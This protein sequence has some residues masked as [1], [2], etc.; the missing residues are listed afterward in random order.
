MQCESF[1]VA[2]PS[3]GDTKYPTNR[4]TN[5]TTDLKHDKVLTDWEVGL[6]QIQF[7]NNWNYSTPEFKFLA[8]VGKFGSGYSQTYPDNY[9]VGDL[10][11]RLR[12][13]G[14]AHVTSI[15]G[16]ADGSSEIINVDSRLVTVPAFDGWR[17]VDEFGV[18]V[19]KCIEDTFDE[20]SERIIR[21]SYER[22]SANI[23]LFRIS[24]NT[25]ESDE[26]GPTFIGM[27]SEDEEM[28]EILG[29]HPRRQSSRL[30]NKNLKVYRFME[31]HPIPRSNG[32]HAI[33]T[34]FLYADVCEQQ[35][36]GSKTG[37]LLKIVP[38]TVGNGQRQCNEYE[39]PSYVPVAPTRLN[40][41][42]IKLCDLTGEELQITD[43]G[44]L[45]TVYLHFRRRKRTDT[46]AGWC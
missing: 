2:L 39:R 23:T 16:N 21:V 43:P 19:A 10:E 36:I 15:Q 6:Q 5:Y 7:T 27:S 3:N 29:I 34:I 4:P 31:K 18:A 44:T 25:V 32:F 14:S 13:I 46:A 1:Y 35:Q 8:W 38:V 9:V 33:E 45:V 22:T 41:I 11:K 20:T 37:T 28:F 40:R 26:V 24:D 42:N 30:S 17:H 12:D